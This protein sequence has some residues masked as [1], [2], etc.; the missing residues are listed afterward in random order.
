MK[1]TIENATRKNR[2]F[3]DMLIREL[4]ID[5]A[6]GY[7]SISR[8]MLLPSY[9][10][11][12]ACVN[13]ADDDNY[14]QLNRDTGCTFKPIKDVVSKRNLDAIDEMLAAANIAPTKNLEVLKQYL[15][16]H[17]QLSDSTLSAA[18]GMFETPRKL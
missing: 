9:V 12:K 2:I 14:F 7:K 5:L 6:Y 17:L 1:N 11:H 4:I 16:D 10:N 18:N 3:Y 13:H 15:K 8:D